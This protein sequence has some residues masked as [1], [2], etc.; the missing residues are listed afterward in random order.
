[1]GHAQKTSSG[2]DE[3][4]DFLN[5]KT[6]SFDKSGGRNPFVNEMIVA[7]VVRELTSRG[8][9]KVD[10]DADLLVVYVA[11]S[12][13]NLQVASLPFYQVVNPAYSGMVGG[14]SM[15]MWDVM[16]GTLVIDL[17]DRKAERT[18]FRGTATEVLKR[19]PSPDAVADAKLVLKPI[20]KAYPKCLKS[21]PSNP[22]SNK[23][24]FDTL[25]TFE[26]FRT[27]D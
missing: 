4:A 9:T 25:L 1:M 20:N 27:V 21:I 5:Y 8:L 15:A 26:R 7:A 24:Y 17:V 22:N 16:T 11:A 18:V 6:F 2:Y 3:N 10:A 19:A 12:G 13:P 14:A 23:R